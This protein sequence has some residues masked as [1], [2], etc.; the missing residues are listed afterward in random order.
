[1][2][3]IADNAYA[4]GIAGNNDNQTRINKGFSTFN[5]I[6]SSASSNVRGLFGAGSINYVEDVFYIGV[7]SNLSLEN[8]SI[9][10]ILGVLKE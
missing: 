7:I 2:I 1:M 10:T 8:S 3:I 5:I 6:S 9:E 4:G